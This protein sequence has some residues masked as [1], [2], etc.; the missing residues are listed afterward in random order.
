[1]EI[2]V[3][4]D[5]ILV[6]PIEAQSEDGLMLDIG[7]FSRNVNTRLNSGVV[8][9]VSNNVESV[10]IGD[11]I[12]YSTYDGV[13]VKHNGKKYILLSQRESQA[14]VLTKN[15]EEVKFKDHDRDD[16]QDYIFRNDLVVT[17]T[18]KL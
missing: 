14:K 12:G 4:K 17:D 5:N 6:S 8:V 11:I 3:F 10:K 16:I 13:N 15:I 2:I 9:S 7:S 1:M 18:L